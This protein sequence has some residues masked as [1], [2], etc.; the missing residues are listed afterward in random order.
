MT[1]AYGQ[2]KVWLQHASDDPQSVVYF[3]DESLKSHRS[4][5]QPKGASP[6]RKEGRKEVAVAAVVFLAACPSHRVERR[7]LP[8]TIELANPISLKLELSLVNVSLSQN[9]SKGVKRRGMRQKCRTPG[10]RAGA[11]F[12]PSKK[13]KKIGKSPVCDRRAIQTNES[14]M[15]ARTHF[16]STAASARNGHTRPGC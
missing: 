12:G 14:Q 11:P 6:R 5:S 4:Q 8:S 13:K 9:D 7:S 16:I 1:L 2:E 10:K 3:E 15:E